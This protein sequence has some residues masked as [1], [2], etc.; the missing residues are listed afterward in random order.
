VE[1]TA[2]GGPAFRRPDH[3]GDVGVV[4]KFLFGA[5]ACHC[6]WE[7]G[8][9]MSAEEQKLM[10]VKA[11]CQIA[12]G[13]AEVV[14]SNDSNAEMYEYEKET[15]QKRKLRAIQ[16]TKSIVDRFYFETALHS[17]ID[18]CIAAQEMDDAGKLFRM[19]SVDAIRE[20][21]LKSHPSLERS[22]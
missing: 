18:L 22:I 12:V 19:I 8:L 1:G 9:S 17:I 4:D 7:Q 10:R 2:S 21:I 15:Y 20:S 13:C 5:Y 6:T 3:R 16:I 14:A 11:M